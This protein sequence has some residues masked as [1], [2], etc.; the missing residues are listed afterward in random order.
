MHRL[1]IFLLAGV[2]VWTS[3]TSRQ[4]PAL[5]D[6]SP[7]SF[8]A[9]HQVMQARGAGRIPQISAHRGGPMPGYPENCLPTF[10]HTLSQ[11]PAML[12]MDISTSADGVLFL[13]HDNSLDRTTNGTGRVRE[14][15]WDYIRQLKLKDNNGTLTDFHP[16]SLEEVLRWNQEVQAILYLDVKRGTAFEEVVRL[17]RKYEAQHLAIIIT[18]SVEDAMR[19]HR[20]GPELMVSVNVRNLE[21]FSWL[22]SSGIPLSQVH[23]FTGTSMKSAELYEVLHREGIWCIVGTMGNLDNRA[24]RTKDRLYR[25]LVQA[26]AD[27]LATDRPVEAG[28]A[29]WEQAETQ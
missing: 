3:C 28:K 8:A 15:D 12:E 4:M 14:R 24:I 13:M 17:V 22:L 23:A 2:L 7:E 19:V 16:P 27:I 25:N 18:Y 11:V 1:I 20:A 6:P 26:G 10:E 5:S 9:T 21:E 29:I